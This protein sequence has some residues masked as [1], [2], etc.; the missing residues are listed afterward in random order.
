MTGRAKRSLSH[1]QAC[2]RP[3]RQPR[4][5]DAGCLC[6]DAVRDQQCL[7][8][9]LSARKLWR[10]TTRLLPLRP[11]TRSLPL[12][13]ATRSLPLRSTARSLP[14]RSTARL[15]PLRST[16]RLLPLR[17]ATRL[18]PLRP[19]ARLLPLR[20]TAA[21]RRW[22]RPPAHGLGLRDLARPLPAAQLFPY[23]RKLH[24]HH[25]RIWPEARRHRILSTARGAAREMSDR[26]FPRAD[27]VSRGYARSWR[28]SGRA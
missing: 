17:P 16:T 20:P 28:R 26:S 25:S 27:G 2:L 15:L 19:T 7:G 12:R 8:P 9:V 21:L 4:Q 22:L 10:S 18:L 3:R 11:A 23:W 24:V 6:L 13:P 5:V 1:V 14:L